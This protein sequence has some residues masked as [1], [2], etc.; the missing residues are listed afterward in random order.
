MT[1]VRV[2]LLLVLGCLSRPQTIDL[3][4]IHEFL[5]TNPLS[6][7]LLDEISVLGSMGGFFTVLDV[8]DIIGNL[9]SRYPGFVSDLKPIGTSLLRKEIKEF[10]LGNLGSLISLGDSKNGG[11]VHGLAS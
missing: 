7:S 3:D 1:C 5:N 2:F 9:T 6:E 8:Y 4:K 10:R 11:P